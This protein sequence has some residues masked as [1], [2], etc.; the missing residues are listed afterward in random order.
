MSPM[1]TGLSPRAL[2]FTVWALALTPALWFATFWLFVLR[3]RLA[4]GRWPAPYNPDPK[5]LGFDLHYYALL[6]GIAGIFSATFT[7]L[8]VTALCWREMK[9][10]G[11]RPLLAASVACVTLTATIVVARSDPGWF[12]AWFGD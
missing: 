10:A 5:D 7:L 1:T 2:R 6:L 8:I 9:T 11:A 4:L 12:F 3:A